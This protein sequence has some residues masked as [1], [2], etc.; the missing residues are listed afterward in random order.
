MGR[1]D[2]CSPIWWSNVYFDYSGLLNW[3]EGISKCSLQNCFENKI[4]F[5]TQFFFYKTPLKNHFRLQL[6]IYFIFLQ[7]RKIKPN[8]LLT[9]LYTLRQCQWPTVSLTELFPIYQNKDWTIRWLDD[10][11]IDPSYHIEDCRI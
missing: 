2:D 10:C 3:P 5:L 4:Q 8:S 7:V 11:P 1:R 6:S 9:V